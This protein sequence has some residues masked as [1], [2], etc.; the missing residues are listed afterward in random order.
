[1]DNV[2]D[3][4]YRGT[5]QEMWDL[6]RDFPN[7]APPYHAFWSEHKVATHIWSVEHGNLDLTSLGIG[8]DARIGWLFIA[9]EPGNIRS[10]PL[11]AETR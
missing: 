1:V 4:Y 8:D 2:A 10:E 7:L 3:Y 6:T 11:P 9:I 5:D